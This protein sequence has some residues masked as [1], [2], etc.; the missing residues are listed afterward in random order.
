MTNTI[1]QQKWLLS[2]LFS[3]TM[4][5]KLEVISYKTA[6][7]EVVHNFLIMT[8]ILELICNYRP[9]LCRK[10]FGYP[11]IPPNTME[12]RI[13][14]MNSERGIQ[15]PENNRTHLILND[16]SVS[17][18]HHSR[19]QGH[20]LSENNGWE[21]NFWFGYQSVYVKW[22]GDCIDISAPNIIV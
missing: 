10:L 4:Q 8:G 14:I 7:V 21:R 1:G 2:S 15:Y 12:M 13:K 5:N 17:F 9:S 11:E 20:C 6:N 3:Y 16:N 18:S 22:S 19:Y